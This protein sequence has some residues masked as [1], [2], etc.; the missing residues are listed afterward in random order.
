MCRCGE[1]G[2]DGETGVF[3]YIAE[4]AEISSNSHWATRN[5]RVYS[6]NASYRITSFRHATQYFFVVD[7]RNAQSWR[8]GWFSTVKKAY[9]IDRSIYMRYLV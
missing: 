4:F 8:C 5:V 1:G 9:D 7:N 3:L 2:V 6:D